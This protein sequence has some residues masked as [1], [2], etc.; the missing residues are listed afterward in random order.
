MFPDVIQTVG[1]MDQ[2]SNLLSDCYSNSLKLANKNELKT[3]V[4][5]DFTF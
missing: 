2:D 1:P 4:S 3:I 5:H